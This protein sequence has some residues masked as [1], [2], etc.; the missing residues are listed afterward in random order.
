MRPRFCFFGKISVGRRPARAFSS[1]PTPL[2]HMHLREVIRIGAAS[3]CALCACASALSQNET[4]SAYSGEVIRA[5]GRPFAGARVVLRH[6]DTGLEQRALTNASGRFAFAGLPP[7]G[8]YRLRVSSFGYTPQI[9]ENI[10]LD[11]GENHAPELRLTRS[12]DTPAHELDAFIVTAA[13]LPIEAGTG[14][15]LA[16]DELDDQPS[17]ERS[18]NEYARTDPHVALIDAERGELTAGGQNTRFN[19]TQIDG[20]RLD[21]LFGLTANGLPSQG[22]PF[23]METVEA[24]SIDV[25]PYDAS[26]GGFTGASVNAVTRSG[27][28]QFSG[29]LYY[30]Y[31]NQNYRARHPVT[32]ERDPFSQYTAGV[33]FGGPLLPKRLFFFAGY[34]RSQRTEPA[35]A[36]GFSPDPVA[37]ERIIS[38]ARDYGHDAGRLINPGSQRKEDNKYLLRLDWHVSP[39]HRISARY[40][41]TR[42]H[43][44]SFVDYSTSGRVSLSGH[45]Y[46]SIQNLDTWSVQAFSRWGD[47]FQTEVKAAGHRY[48]SGREPYTRFP[49]VRINGVPAE[50]G[51]GTG[52]VFL[53][54][55]ESSQVNDLSVRNF[56]SAASGTWLLGKHRL[57]LGVEAERSDFDNTYLQNAYGAYSFAS[58]N[59]FAAGTPSAFTYQYMLPGRRP[60][61]SWGYTTQV[62]FL[63]D[64][65]QITPRF[66][67]T[68]GVRFER[69]LTT[70]KPI[71]NERFEEVFGRRNDRTI[72]GASLLAPRFGAVWKFGKRGRGTL[73][74]GA[75]VFRGKAPGVW[76]SNPYSNDGLSSLVNTSISRFSPDPDNQ[77]T[78]NPATRRQRVDLLDDDF[79]MPTVARANLAVEHRLPWLGFI[80]SAEA[81]QTWTLEG[82]TYRNLNLRRT[83]T[84]PDG[85][86]IYGNRTASFALSSNSQYQHSEYA[87]VYLLTNTDRGRAT[88]LTAR[89]RRPLRGF[90][91]ASFS[92]TRSDVREVS[93]VTSSTAA[94]NFSTRMSLDP[95]DEEPGT[96]STQIRDR[97]L[98]SG[99]LRFSFI[100]RLDT[101]ITLAYEGRSGRPYSFIFGSDVNGDSAD[102][103]NDLFYV[104]AGPSDPKVRWASAEQKDAF[105]TYQLSNPRL[106]RFA[107]QVVPRNS[108]RS[109]FVHQF[110]LKLSQQI[111]LWRT[112]RAEIFG[113]VINLGNLLNPRWGRIEQVSFPY[114]LIVAN[115]SYDPTA[116]QY[117]YRYTAARTETLQ[118]G[119][120]RWQ[121]QGGVRVRF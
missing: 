17:I 61:V 100:R 97:I 52:S 43:M 69:L 105:F 34:E 45:W 60:S 72:N 77:P 93:P 106:A 37:L 41:Q 4:V 19:S 57:S 83:G 11:L 108:E 76:L 5:S 59:A 35:P 28:N 20:V 29:S 31:R 55:D 63:Q 22:N 98:A 115:A 73:R 1:R 116:N 112:W 79:Q 80:A 71:R 82:L 111:T 118:P 10:V 54:T 88:Q 119:P 15:I 66:N 117:V 121:I 16:G 12:A 74:G 7:G 23:S 33:T 92:Y 9:I 44:P 120:S 21:D 85:R 96:A 94:T 27:T 87:D 65:W 24:V 2:P 107:G 25:A 56:Q 62:V 101:R 8:P 58:V 18:L 90:W 48:A 103:S 46:Q 51:S 30:S 40:S 102:Y 64:R 104:P 53:G 95:N 50:D 109:R 26:R 32:G 86:A 68:A 47:I 67:V 6:T 3:L 70:D 49:Q 39:A 84:G 13:R 36:P 110:D 75:G 81:L 14:S 89:L 38:I 114:G 113:D 78:G 91:G 42:G 99:T